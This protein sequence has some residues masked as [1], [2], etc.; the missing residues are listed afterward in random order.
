[1]LAV[2]IAS[3][4][5]GTAPLVDLHSVDPTIRVDLSYDHPKNAFRRQLYH[6][7]V[8]LLR[9]PVAQRL[10]RVQATLAK[11]GLG[12]KVWDAYRPRTVQAEMWRLRPDGHSRYVANPRKISK[13]SRG[14]AVDVTLVDR[15]G[16]ELRMPTPHD[17]FSPRAFRAA[18]HGISPEAR[19][20]RAVL[21]SAMQAQGFIS[22]PYEWWHF[23]APEW[24]RYP[25]EGRA[26]PAA[27]R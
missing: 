10:A 15:N 5:R 6:S 7:N 19:R 21:Q 17:E 13:H 27:N 2:T 12:L 1:M 9:L 8:A 26:L 25:A 11:R 23:T 4:A 14:A 24:S 20:N 22:N 18:T 3:A 16:H